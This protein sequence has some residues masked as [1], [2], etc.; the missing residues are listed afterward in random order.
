MGYLGFQPGQVSGRVPTM[1]RGSEKSVAPSAAGRVLENVDL[2]GSPLETSGIIREACSGQNSLLQKFCRD[3]EGTGS[4]V[5]SYFISPHIFVR[6]QQ[7]ALICIC[8]LLHLLL[9]PVYALFY[10]LKIQRGEGNGNPL[11]YSCLE[12]PMDGGA[13]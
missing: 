3:S 9:N 8:S 10:P 6:A 13:W 12:N 4:S 2:W 5:N 11:Q 7:V 1:Q